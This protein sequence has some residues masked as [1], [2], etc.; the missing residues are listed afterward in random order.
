MTKKHTLIA[1]AALALS[2]TALCL[3][4]QAS[5]FC[6]VKKS[7]DGF[8]AL[9]ASP[10]A[11]SKMLARMKANDEVFLTGEKRNGWERIKYWP[12]NDRLTKGESARTITGWVNAKLIDMCG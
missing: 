6:E 5:L 7:R 11:G 2:Y 3:P 8:V 10:D 4:A 9:R 1:A 12:A